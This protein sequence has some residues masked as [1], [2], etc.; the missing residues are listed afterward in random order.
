MGQV[1]DETHFLLHC[2]TYQQNRQQ[3]FENIPDIDNFGAMTDQDKL[4]LLLNDRSMVKK[5][6]IFIAES[7]DYTG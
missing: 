2:N 6:S 5:T 1:E 4:K 7:F 3:L